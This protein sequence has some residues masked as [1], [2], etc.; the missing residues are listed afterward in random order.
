MGLLGVGGLL[1]GVIELGLH[2]AIAAGHLV[3]ATVRGLLAFGG[4]TF[5]QVGHAAD[6]G[7]AI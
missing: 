5:G 2:S 4:R 7:C 6:D 3:A 1:L